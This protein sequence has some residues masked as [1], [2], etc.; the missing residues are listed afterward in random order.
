MSA[1]HNAYRLH[2]LGPCALEEPTCVID[3]PKVNGRVL[4]A[5]SAASLLL[6]PRGM[7]TSFFGF[8][9][10]DE[11]GSI[12]RR[13]LMHLPMDMS[14]FR[15]YPGPSAKGAARHAGVAGLQLLHDRA[16]LHPE[17]PEAMCTQATWLLLDAPFHPEAPEASRAI[18]SRMAEVAER[19]RRRGAFCAVWFDAAGFAANA[20]A[21]FA[22][23]SIDLHIISDFSTE[24]EIETQGEAEK[25]PWPEP[26]IPAA[27]VVTLK[28]K[29]IRL[30]SR[31][32]LYGRV[33]SEISGQYHAP[34]VIGALLAQGLF[35][36][37]DE[38]DHSRVD[39][40]IDR[41]RVAMQPLHL[42]LGLEWAQLAAGLVNLTAHG[43]PFE[44]QKGE[45]LREVEKAW[46][47]RHPERFTL[48][49]GRHVLSR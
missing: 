29:A 23:E 18:L 37:F 33:Q 40:N 4:H 13:A 12:L 21:D 14:Y 6:K 24:A 5:L 47:Q 7:A 19:A 48:W 1:A 16:Q 49:G 8:T 2:A 42:G 15:R 11:I 31:G 46:R 43:L 32:G 30:Q 3:S 36:I 20:Y 39:V 26:S 44:S 25:K 38:D 17:W 28:P 10:E 27:T 34:T 22:H 41:E 9:G 45:W 35:E